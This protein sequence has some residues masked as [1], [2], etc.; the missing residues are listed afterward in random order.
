MSRSRNGRVIQAIKPHAADASAMALNGDGNLTPQE[1]VKLLVTSGPIIGNAVRQLR[2][3]LATRRWPRAGC[4][5]LIGRTGRARD[6]SPG[7]RRC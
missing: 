1:R 4:G 5:L 7:G 6:G 3:E 2:R